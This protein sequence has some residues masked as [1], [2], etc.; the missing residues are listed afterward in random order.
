M[1]VQIGRVQR[2]VCCHFAA[3]DGNGPAAL[4][5][6]RAFDLHFFCSGGRI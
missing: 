5:G 1:S 2:S 4:T 6:G 3:I